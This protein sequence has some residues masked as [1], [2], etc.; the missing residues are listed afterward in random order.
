M[1]VRG[2]IYAK[3]PNESQSFLN[4]LCRSAINNFDLPELQGFQEFSNT[5]FAKIIFQESKI[6][7]LQIENYKLVNDVS[8]IVDNGIFKLPYHDNFNAEKAFWQLNKR[9]IYLD[10]ISFENLRIENQNYFS[11]ENIILKTKRIVEPKQKVSLV[12]KACV[13]D[14]EIIYEAVK[15]IVR[16]LS[17]SECF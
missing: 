2:F 16:Q 5:L 12:I 17:F 9:N 1:A 11:P 3:Y 7:T 13:Q 8:E 15:H 4:K 14:T 6:E 10:E